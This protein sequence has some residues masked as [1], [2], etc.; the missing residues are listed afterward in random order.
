MKN[1]SHKRADGLIISLLILPNF[2]QIF[3]EHP[4]ISHKSQC[5]PLYSNISQLNPH[6]ES[7]RPTLFFPCR[8]RNYIH[9]LQ[10]FSNLQAAQPWPQQFKYI[11]CRRES[12]FSPSLPRRPPRNPPIPELT[13]AESGRRSEKNWCLP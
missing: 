7:T 2:P 3:R 1:S 8:I 13:R 4:Q 11:T 10:G 6:P 12:S 9:T 5:S